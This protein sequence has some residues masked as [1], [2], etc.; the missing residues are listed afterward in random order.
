ML[1]TEAALIAVCPT[2]A[3]QLLARGFVHARRI[4]HASTRRRADR[5][6]GRRLELTDRVFCS[7]DGASADDLSRRLRFEN[8]WFFCERID[9]A[10]LFCGWPLDDNELGET[11][12]QESTSFLQFFVAYR[13]ERLEDALD[14]P[15]RQ[16]VRVLISNFLNKLTLGHHLGHVRAPVCARIAHRES[17]R[18]LS[19]A[20][21][22]SPLWRCKGD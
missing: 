3:G 13:G 15:P 5:A 22:G 12:H 17:S 18:N 16:A 21:R 11:R 8:R 14:V 19:S 4:C 6:R 1:R 7:L 10:P 20:E 2:G 9:S